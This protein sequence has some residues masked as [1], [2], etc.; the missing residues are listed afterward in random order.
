M[1]LLLLAEVVLCAEVGGRTGWVHTS[2]VHFVVGAA[3]VVDEDVGGRIG[4]VQTSSVHFVVV[5]TAA[6]DVE[7]VTPVKIEGVVVE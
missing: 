4:W 1:H 3:V 5:G 7:R 6:L 2:R